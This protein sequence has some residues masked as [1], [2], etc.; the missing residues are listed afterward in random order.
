MSDIFDHAVDAFESAVDF[1]GSFDT[2]PDISTSPAK[3]RIARAVFNDGFEEAM[4]GL[5]FL[6]TANSLK[7]FN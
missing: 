1:D 5:R 2:L 3:R 7:M 4:D 6:P